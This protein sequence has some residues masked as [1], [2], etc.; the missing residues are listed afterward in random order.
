VT[1]ELTYPP[2]DGVTVS[3]EK[4]TLT[5]E[6][7]PLEVRVTG[8]EY[9]LTEVIATTADPSPP[10]ET[11]KLDG[12]TEILKSPGAGAAVTCKVKS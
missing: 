11:V 10:G 12:E 3:G 4:L 5:P 9:S 2:G 8:D 7:C 6:G 1:A